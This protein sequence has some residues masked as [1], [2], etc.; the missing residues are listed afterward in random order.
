[1][2]TFWLSSFTPTR[3]CEDSYDKLIEEID[4]QAVASQLSMHYFIGNDYQP[5]PA[6]LSRQDIEE[7]RDIFAKYATDYE[8]VIEDPTSEHDSKRWYFPG[9]PD[10]GTSQPR[11]LL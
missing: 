8:F 2:T 6:D 9:A 11:E 5:M 4:D 1:M 7:I 3:E 10:D